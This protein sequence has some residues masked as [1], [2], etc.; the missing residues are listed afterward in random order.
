M[1]YYNQ[2]EACPYW[3]SMVLYPLILPAYKKIKIVIQSVENFSIQTEVYENA[4]KYLIL[5]NY[6]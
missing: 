4:V 5:H 6:S 2:S 1:N 3:I